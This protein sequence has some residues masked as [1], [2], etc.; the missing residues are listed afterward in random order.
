MSE[1]HPKDVDS[2]VPLLYFVE[3]YRNMIVE[4]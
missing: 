1:L 3:E 2:Y 4:K